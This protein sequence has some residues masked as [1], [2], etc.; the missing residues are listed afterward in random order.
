M[1]TVNKSTQNFDDQKH[2]ISKLEKCTSCNAINNS[3]PESQLQ[4]T[5]S[6]K[7]I[8]HKRKQNELSSVK[9]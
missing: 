3:H 6:P 9:E 8:K 1:L 2:F 5:A 7:C 4:S